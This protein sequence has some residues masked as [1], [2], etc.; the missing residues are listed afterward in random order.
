MAKPEHIK[1]LRCGVKSW[2][3]RRNKHPF[4]PDFSG[5]YIPTKLQE[6]SYK[7]KE[8]L[9]FSLKG[10]DL[11][12]ADF[13]NAGL[14]GL[15][16]R[17]ANLS[18]AKLREADL[19]LIDLR[20]AELIGTDFSKAS[21]SRAKLNGVVAHEAKFTGANLMGASLLG[22]QLVHADFTRANLTDA[23][24]KDVDLRQAN[25]IGADITNTQ[26]WKSVLYT[27][28]TNMQPYASD[29]SE[30]IESVGDLVEKCE[31]L[32]KYYEDNSEE[33]SFG[34]GFRFY[35]R[36]ERAGSW[37]LRPSVMRSLRRKG[38]V[39]RETEGEMLLELMS[40]RPED[41]IGAT[42]ALS[43]WVVAQQHG[44]KTR[45]LDITQNP[46]VALFH[47]C[48][49][50]SVRD[51]SNGILHVFVVPKCIVKSFDSDAISVVANFAKLPRFEQKRL[52]GN[53]VN[54]NESIQAQEMGYSYDYSRIMR[55]LY[56]H[57]RREKPHF[58]KL[59]DIRDLLRVFVVEPQQSFER[60]RVQSGAFLVSA[61]HERFE[62]DQILAYN[63]NTPVYDHYKL[64]VPSAN[65]KKILHE[66]RLL[67][68]KR[69]V[70]F[71]GLDEAAEAIVGSNS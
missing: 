67:N 23:K 35:F 41:F 56:H 11:R 33:S 49:H 1:W 24:I 50:L 38:F 8:R 25:L 26:P 37:P 44:L 7:E 60:I 14:F 64:I 58:K 27:G 29:S 18:R 59:I 36:G 20:G 46:L 40:K 13:C 32:E 65:K 19:G 12:Y 70:L 16:L 42:S 71:P 15:D 2:N 48:E 22:A 66:L 10:I 30:K 57:I 45:L 6:S 62:K 63:K 28:S 17:D 55:R 54:N 9:L 61:F 53:S 21:L 5:V 34:N 68:I 69:E 31:A 39:F 52:L 3:E 51:K 4:R 47:A 43:Q